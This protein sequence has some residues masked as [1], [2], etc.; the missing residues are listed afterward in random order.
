MREFTKK[1][2][3][4]A[5]AGEGAGSAADEK[6]GA[7]DKPISIDPEDEVAE[8]AS[9]AGISE[10]DKVGIPKLTG[11]K[12]FASISRTFPK[13]RMDRAQMISR[14]IET[15]YRRKVE[16]LYVALESFEIER[17]NLLDMAPDSALSTKAAA[18]V[19]PKAFV[20]KDLELSLMIRKTQIEY[21]TAKA[22]YNE[23]FKA[24]K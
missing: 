21:Y 12:L 22:R 5:P 8:L 24:S 9:A 16:D 11:G 13:I 2:E 4:M 10:E 3:F 14:S 1:M 7:P 6:S 18:N 23:L 20:T 19:D 15:L 17:E